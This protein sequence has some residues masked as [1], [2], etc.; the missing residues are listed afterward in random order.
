VNIEGYSYICADSKLHYEFESVGPNGTVLKVV[1][2]TLIDKQEQL[3]NL[4]LGDFD[5]LTNKVLDNVVTDNKDT[6][7]VLAT[8]GEIGR[9]FLNENFNFSIYFEGN[10]QSKNRLYRKGLNLFLEV[11][12]QYYII[13]GLKEQNLKWERFNGNTEYIAFIIKNK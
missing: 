11:I 3:F 4:G 1:Q 5:P 8:V 7:K 12:E 2:F 13:N 6:L 10:T 9:Q